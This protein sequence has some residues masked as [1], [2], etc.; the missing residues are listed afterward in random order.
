MIRKLLLVLLCAAGVS[1]HA[2]LDPAQVRRLAADDSADKVAA[3]RQ[4]TRTADPDAARVLQ[5]MADD[6]LYVAKENGRNQLANYETLLAEG[7]IS[8]REQPSGDI[9]LF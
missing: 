9:E 4:L 2:A 6:A 7:M 1:A 8:V 5:A 3:I